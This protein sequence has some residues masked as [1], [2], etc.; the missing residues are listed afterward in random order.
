M[1]RTSIF[2]RR[3]VLVKIWDDSGLNILTFR[4][5]DDSPVLT[6]SNLQDNLLTMMTFSFKGDFHNKD[7]RKEDRMITEDNTTEMDILLGTLN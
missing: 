7:K 2:A 1:S 3:R 6:E 5:A 4:F